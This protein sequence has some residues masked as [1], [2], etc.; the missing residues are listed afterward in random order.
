MAIVLA[1]IG[2]QNYTLRFMYSTLA[3]KLFCSCMCMASATAADVVDNDS[4]G[5]GGDGARAHLLLKQY[6]SPHIQTCGVMV[7]EC[8]TLAILLQT[9]RQTRANWQ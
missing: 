8:D 9:L 6:R 1:V 5:G 7:V 4:S 2:C 3:V